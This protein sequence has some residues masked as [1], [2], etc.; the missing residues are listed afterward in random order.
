M[1]ER[2]IVFW[3]GLI[4]FALAL[5]ELF[6]IAWMMIWF[7]PSS[8]FMKGLVP[9]IVAGVVFTVIGVWMM[10]SGKKEA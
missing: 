10:K 2:T 7:P 9:P 3:V 8:E 6:G 1:K 4:L 5:V